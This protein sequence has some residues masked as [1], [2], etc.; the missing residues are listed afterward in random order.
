MEV[1][2]A[3]PF[4]TMLP[5]LRS[6][7]SGLVASA[8]LVEDFKATPKDGQ[9]LVDIFLHNRLSKGT[10]LTKL[11]HRNKR[12]NFANVQISGLSE[13]EDFAQ[14]SGMIQLKATL[15]RRLTEECLSII[16]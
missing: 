12:K 16:M 11:I 14:G 9:T 13:M 15:E 8:E 6:L 5:T 10:F 1:F 7:Q 2:D 4:P 3:D